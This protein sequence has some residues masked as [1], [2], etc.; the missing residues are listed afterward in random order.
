MTLIGSIAGQ[1][2]NMCINGRNLPS[3]CW[4]FLASLSSSIRLFK[5]VTG[6]SSIFHL[7]K[8]LTKTHAVLPKVKVDTLTSISVSEAADAIAEQTKKDTDA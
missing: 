5:L 3:I 7:S 4:N 2:S 8:I 1:L 6:G